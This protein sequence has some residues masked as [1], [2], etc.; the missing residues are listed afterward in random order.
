[1]PSENQAPKRV[2]EL[3]VGMGE[4]VRRAAYGDG[5]RR[6]GRGTAPDVF[7]VANEGVAGATD[8]GRQ[9]A[10]FAVRTA[11][12]FGELLESLIGDESRAEGRTSPST[13]RC[14]DT[15]GSGAGAP[16]ESSG[17]TTTASFDVRNDGSTWSTG[18]ACGAADSSALARGDIPGYRLDFIPPVVDVRAGAAVDRRV[19]VVVP[20]DTKRGR[21][22]GVIEVRPV[23]RVCSSWSHSMSSEQLAAE[24]LRV[25]AGPGD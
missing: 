22:F 20:S 14:R 11:I 10:G 25:P 9:I 12:E 7:N 3:V 8:I 2:V 13:A 4:Q 18:C 17:L 16:S 6:G 1:M 19:P 23:H 24:P 5:A 21:Y 15:A